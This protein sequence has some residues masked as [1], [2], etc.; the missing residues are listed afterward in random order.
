MVG[1][2]DSLALESDPEDPASFQTDPLRW[3]PYL[4]LH[5][6][7]LGVLWVGWSWTAIGVAAALYVL[8]MFAITGFYHRYFSHRTFRTSRLVQFLMGVAGNSSAQRGPLWWAAQHRRHH[9]HSDEHEDPHSPHEHGVYWSHVGWL[10]VRANLTT[11]LRVVPDLAQFRELRF[12]D[13]F[14][15]LVPVLMAVA[16]YIFGAVLAQA[17]PQLG[18]S[19]PQM[20]VWGFFISTVVLFHG[21][22]LINSLA[23][24]VGSRR[25]DTKDESRNNWVLA[26][27]TL[28]EGWHNNHHRYPSSARQGFYWW[29]IDITY[30]GLKLLER[31]G[32]IWDVRPVPARILESGRSRRRAA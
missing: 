8:R 14:D 19:G 3:V 26:L 21:T 5:G 27:L 17:A 30:Y 25:Y 16:L 20:L 10:T 11:D 29:E 31:L 15:W 12:I 23:H 4:I 28:G 7:C 24:V 22:C 6:G 13:R 1:W 9:S 32:I 18:T 2:V